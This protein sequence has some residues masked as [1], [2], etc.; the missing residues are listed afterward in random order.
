MFVTLRRFNFMLLEKLTTFELPLKGMP[1]GTQQFE[2]HLG[3]DF[4][5]EMEST[6]VLSAAVDTTVEVK[7]SGD[8]YELC[9]TVAGELGIPC[10]RCLEPMSHRVDAEY[11]VSVKYGEEY[12]DDADNVIVIAESSNTMN[13]AGLIFDTIMLTIPIKHVHPEGGCDA[14]MQAQLD[15]HRATIAEEDAEGWS[16]GEGESD[17]VNDDNF[18]CDPRWEALRKLKDNN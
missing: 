4:F 3:M 1:C 7:R 14:V 16:D 11:R 2:Y 5:R 17:N 10:D 9:I 15:A 8:I 12:S 18:P 6:D 13:V